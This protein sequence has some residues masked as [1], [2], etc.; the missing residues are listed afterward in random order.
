MYAADIYI[1]GIFSRTQYILDLRI[2]IGKF[3]FVCMILLT[4]IST[5]WPTHK[6]IHYLPLAKIKTDMT[7]L[8]DLFWPLMIKYNKYLNHLY[9]LHFLCVTGTIVLF[10]ILLNSIFGRCW[11]RCTHCITPRNNNYFNVSSMIMMQVTS[12]IHGVVLVLWQLKV[13]VYIFWRRSKYPRKN[14][15]SVNCF[16]SG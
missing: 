7:N 16:I 2:H 1:Q 13:K 14:M 8:A 5:Y 11:L 6:K 12:P 10:I 3:Y 4:W 15:L 9:S